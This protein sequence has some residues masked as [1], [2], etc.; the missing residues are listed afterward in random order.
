MARVSGVLFLVFLLLP[1]TAFAHSSVQGMEGF[2]SGFLHPL[3][4]TAQALAIAALGILVG[5]H[6]SQVANKAAFAFFLALLVGLSAAFVH[7]DLV[8]PDPLLF[9]LALI[10]GVLVAMARPVGGVG[11]VMVASAIGVAVGV[12][13]MPDPGMVSAMAITSAGSFFGANVLFLYAFIGAHWVLS[14]TKRPWLS[15][16]LRILGSW[17][18]AACVLML[19]LATRA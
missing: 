1:K 17:I 5:H 13:S 18:A 11:L 9:V 8:V 16:G 2:Y 7:R 3:K 10:A 4:E 14:Q 19:A 6:P 12:M 15:I